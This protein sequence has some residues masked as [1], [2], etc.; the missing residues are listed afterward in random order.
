MGKV[1]FFLHSNYGLS[2]IL[3]IQL[4]NRVSLTIQLSKPF[5]FGHPVILLDGFADVDDTWQWA[6]MSV[7]FFIS[8]LFLYFFPPLSTLP[9][10]LLGGHGGRH[11]MASAPPSS[12]CCAGGGATPDPPRGRSREG[13]RHQNRRREGGAGE[14]SRR[15]IRDA[16]PSPPRSQRSSRRAS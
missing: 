8:L 15:R 3:A 4:Q 13:N 1:F 9:A 2:L 5:T 6:H 10:P 12:T 16:L 14:G 7:Y 11:A